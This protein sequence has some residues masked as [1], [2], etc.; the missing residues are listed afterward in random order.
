MEN[1]NLETKKGNGVNIVLVVIIVLLAGAVGYLGGKMLADK[2]E[3]NNQEKMPTE[4]KT[5]VLSDEEALQK[6]NELYKIGSKV[7]EFRENSLSESDCKKEYDEMKKYF[8][9]NAKISFLGTY[10]TDESDLTFGTLESAY[11]YEGKLSCEAPARGSYLYYRGEDELTIGTKEE[12]KIVFNK[13]VT[14]CDEDSFVDEDTCKKEVT[15]TYR[16]IIEKEDS[17]WKIAQL[18]SVN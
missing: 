18:S 2:E 8:T 5:K 9:K 6:G 11:Y 3:D 12:N 1:N 10:F 17:E 13:K 15:S 14:Y 16:F 7:V 4:E